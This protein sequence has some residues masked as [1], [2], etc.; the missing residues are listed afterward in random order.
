MSS[1]FSPNGVERVALMDSMVDWC[2]SMVLFKVVVLLDGAL[3][4]DGALQASRCNNVSKK[5]VDWSWQLYLSGDILF[6][7][8][9]IMD[10]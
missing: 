10:R 4:E 9:N 8:C 1:W 5:M 3:Q 2:S 6:R 7:A